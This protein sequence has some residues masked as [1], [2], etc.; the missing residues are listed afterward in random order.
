M[1]HL[2]VANRTLAIYGKGQQVIVSKTAG[3]QSDRRHD[4]F[5]LC[6]F[7]SF[8]NIVEKT[9]DTPSAIITFFSATVLP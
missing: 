6:I 3:K 2:L 9:S 8:N 1:R 5:V 7:S 4:Y